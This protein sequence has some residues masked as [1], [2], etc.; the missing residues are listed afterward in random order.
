MKTKQDLIVEKIVK[1]NE[2]YKWGKLKISHS[3][4]M[5]KYKQLKSD[6]KAANPN[7]LLNVMKAFGAISKR[8]P[9]YPG[10]YIYVG[11]N[12]TAKFAS[13]SCETT[14]WEV[15]IWEDD[16]DPRVYDEFEDY[17][18]YDRKMDV[19]DALYNFDRRLSEDIKI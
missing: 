7:T 2:D 6:H 19:M 16:V 13:A 1:L 3:Q 18:R 10:C 9:E 8:D 15:S 11:V 12:F 17:N 4:Y 5:K 14:W